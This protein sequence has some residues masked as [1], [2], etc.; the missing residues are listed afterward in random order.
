MKRIVGQP[1]KPGKKIFDI[2]RC[3]HKH[4]TLSAKAQILYTEI[5]MRSID[6]SYCWPSQILLAKDLNIQVRYV[7]KCLSELK[8]EGLIRTEKHKHRNRYYTIWTQYLQDNIQQENEGNPALEQAQTNMSEQAQTNMSLINE[9]FNKN[10]STVEHKSKD[11]YTNSPPVSDRMRSLDKSSRHAG[12]V[13]GKQTPSEVKIPDRVQEII[14][15]YYYHT[16]RKIPDPSTKIFK[17]IINTTKRALNGTL[18]NGDQSLKAYSNRR[19][20][21]D[22]IKQAIDK[23]ALT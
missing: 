10:N 23:H 20:S 18:I 5:C 16:D 17:E 11:L 14:D 4:P 8:K 1:F 19:F 12:S 22:E 3:I 9:K 13:Q 2:I 7:I 6:K 15:H 21:V